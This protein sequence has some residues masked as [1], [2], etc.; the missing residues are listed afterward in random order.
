MQRLEKCRLLTHDGLD[1]R[2]AGPIDGLT[3]VSNGFSLD[4][5]LEKY[6]CF[7]Q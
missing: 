1:V 5:S 2:L 4:V 3:T 6:I 7:Q